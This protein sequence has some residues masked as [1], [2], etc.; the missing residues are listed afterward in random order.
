MYKRQLEKLFNQLISLKNQLH[1]EKEELLS[2]LILGIFD[3]S[4]KRLDLITIGDGLVAANG[5]IYEYEQED[6]PDYLGYH[7]SE[8]FEAWYDVQTQK[9]ELKNISNFTLSTDGIFTFK[10]F[11]GQN[12]PTI[13]E[14]EILNLLLLSNEENKV[15]NLLSK[16]MLK[17][18][19]KYGL[20]PSDDL[21]MIQVVLF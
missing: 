2:T 5:V 9:L 11:D 14:S 16:K 13:S 15:E 3:Q 19:K 1:L 12:Y 8:N 17:I 18:E 4:E 6:K 7:L 21:T 10:N 20:K